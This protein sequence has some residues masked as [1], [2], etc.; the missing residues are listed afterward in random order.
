MP[1]T[2]EI[3]L[4]TAMIGASFGSVSFAGDRLP[5]EVPA[6]TSRSHPPVEQARITSLIAELDSDRY[7]VRESATAKLL[8]LGSIV[9]EP[10]GDTLSEG[11]LE[12]VIRGM[13]ILNKMAVSEDSNERESAQIVLQ[14]IAQS[15]E[16]PAA[17][18]AGRL[19]CLFE[20]T[21]KRSR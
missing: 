16:G 8:A 5:A 1:R 21:R 9:A 4:T 13:H 10:L 12:L 14:R 18:R 19:Y 3:L 6:D 17:R 20:S 15:S 11:S 7:Q 2:L